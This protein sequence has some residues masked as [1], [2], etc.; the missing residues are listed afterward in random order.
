MKEKTKQAFLFA[1]SGSFVAMSMVGIVAAVVS[2]YEKDRNEAKRN[3]T[4]EK[5]INKVDEATTSQKDIYK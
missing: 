3:K 1:V 2:K 4:D 5:I